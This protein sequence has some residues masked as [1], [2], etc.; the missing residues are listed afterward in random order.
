MQ[1]EILSLDLDRLD[2][3]PI[4]ISYV[5][6]TM[7][8]IFVTCIVALRNEELLLPIIPG[9]NPTGLNL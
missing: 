6:R 4:S 8:F 7:K 3:F 5:T 2:I 1:G 9:S